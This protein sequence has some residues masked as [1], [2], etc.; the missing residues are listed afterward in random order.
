MPHLMFVPF[1][2]VSI[3]VSTSKASGNFHRAHRMLG[4]PSLWSVT[5]SMFQPTD[6]WT[7]LR[8]TSLLQAS[9]LQ[10]DCNLKGTQGLRESKGFR[11]Q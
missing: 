1:G 3:S 10:L 11:Y 6:R 5:S 2:D 7:N 9:S 4:A 8:C